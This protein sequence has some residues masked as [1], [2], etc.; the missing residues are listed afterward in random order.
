V[1]AGPIARFRVALSVVPVC[2]RGGPPPAVAVAVEVEP[3]GH[4][5]CVQET[6]EA[7]VAAE[8]L[9]IADFPDEMRGDAAGLPGRAGAAD[10]QGDLAL[11]QRGVVDMKRDI[12]PLKNASASSFVP[13]PPGACPL[14]CLA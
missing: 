12:V 6:L 11:G 4:V 5:P 13:L 10:H 14:R 9:L 2:A 1:Y 3:V 7:T 8:P